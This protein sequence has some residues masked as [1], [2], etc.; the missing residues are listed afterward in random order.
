MVDQLVPVPA[1]NTE[2]TPTDR[3]RSLRGS[4][5]DPIIFNFQQ[6]TATTTAERAGGL[7]FHRISSLSLSR[8]SYFECDFGTQVLR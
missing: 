6:D 4:R 2:S 3:M 5:Y 1:F 8:N 7:D